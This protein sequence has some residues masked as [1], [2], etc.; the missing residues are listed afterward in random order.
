M[1]TNF[2][3]KWGSGKP[4]IVIETEVD[5]ARG[6][7]R[8]TVHAQAARRWCSRHMEGHNTH[9]GV[10]TAAAFAVKQTLENT[11][12]RARSRYTSVREESLGSRPFVVR[13]GISKTST[14]SSTW[15]IGDNFTTGAG[16]Q[17]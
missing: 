11:I 1:P 6:S 17:D 16:L 3:A 10:S 9:S 15:H 13:A 2:W 14:P 4:Y 8:P 5:P 12:C 7:Q